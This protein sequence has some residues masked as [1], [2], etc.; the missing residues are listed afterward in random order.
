MARFCMILSLSLLVLSCNPYFYGDYFPLEEGRWWRYEKGGI[1]LNIEVLSGE[2]SLFTLIFGDE[3]REFIKTQDEILEVK[4]VRF[5]YEGDVYDGGEC[6]L[7]FLRLPLLDGDRWEQRFSKN[8]GYPS[9][10]FSIHRECKVDWV[11]DFEGY[12]DVYLF[13][14]VEKDSFPSSMHERHDTLYLA[15]G[16]GIICFNGWRL[17]EWGNSLSQ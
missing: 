8:V 12:S 11:G 13:I 1:N 6:I 5:F 16:I 10:G 17:V 15:P 7:T 2:D 9:I 14:I 4:R 3:L